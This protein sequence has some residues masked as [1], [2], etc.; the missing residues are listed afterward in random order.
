MLL[1]FVKT[2]HLD[3]NFPFSNLKTK[4]RVRM[5]PKNNIQIAPISNSLNVDST[6]TAFSIQIKMKVPELSFFSVS[7]FSRI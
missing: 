3:K 2:M 4:Y 1:L 6:T 7:E 5:N